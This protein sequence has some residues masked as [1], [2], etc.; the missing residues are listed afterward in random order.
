MKLEQRLVFNTDLRQLQKQI[1]S[2]RIIQSIKILQLATPELDRLVQEELTENPTLEFAPAEGGDEVSDGLK[3]DPRGE[4]SVDEGN[5][6]ERDIEFLERYN[7][8][9]HERAQRA[10]ANRLAGEEDV[11]QEALN[12]T[13]AKGA[14]LSQYLTD[15]LSLM[16]LDECI[17]EAAGLIIAALDADGLLAL[18]LSD[19]VGNRF[20]EG[21]I[22]VAQEALGVVQSMDPAGVGAIDSQQALLLQINPDDQD[23]KLYESV[24]KDHW[25][26]M[27]RNKIPKIAKETNYSIDDVKFA[28]EQIVTLNPYPGREFNSVSTTAITPD[29]VIEERESDPG[30]YRVRMIDDYL[31]RLRV[32]NTY[33]K[34]L[35]SAKDKETTEYLKNKI[36]GA[37]A[38]IE[39]VQQRQ[40]TLERV[41]NSILKHQKEFMES[42]V[43]GLKSLKMQD[44]GDELKIHVSTVCRAVADK[45]VDTPQGIYALKFFFV[46]GTETT[47]G[48]DTSRHAIKE[49][50][51]EIIEN[52]DST[53]PLSD[54]AVAKML[55]T[56]LD[57]KIARRTVAKYRDQLDIPDSRQRKS[58]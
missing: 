13:P 8:E 36:E 45:Y 42:G 29:I 18:E 40:S 31:P 46:G 37:R 2:P 43:A 4:E 41:G 49:E 34:L 48:E 5:R 20:G 19:V 17:K 58:Y 25:D 12:N 22:D 10:T 30:E 56:K 38:L 54:D 26:D 55:S 11:K 50:L 28:I 39:A 32:S 1:L 27:L 9:F 47:E 33:R 53:K 23:Y 21:S 7:D 52:E 51:R 16:E 14:T 6:L 3:V 24:L 57:I 35:E 44:V 15:Q